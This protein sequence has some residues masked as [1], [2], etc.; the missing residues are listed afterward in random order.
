[1]AG[2]ITK[3]MESEFFKLFN[4]FDFEEVNLDFY[5]FYRFFFRFWFAKGGRQKKKFCL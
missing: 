1:V 5:T 2:S 4:F 3:Q